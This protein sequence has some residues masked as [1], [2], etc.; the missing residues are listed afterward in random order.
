MLATQEMSERYELLRTGRLM[1]YLRGQT[2]RATI[3]NS[4]FVFDLSEA[5]LKAAL[6][7]APVELARPVKDLLSTKN[8]VVWRYES[9]ASG[10]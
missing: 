6:N 1:A 7:E 8:G 4:I 9:I 2:P 3:A 10:P 5:D